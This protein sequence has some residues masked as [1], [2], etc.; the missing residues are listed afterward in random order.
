[1]LCFAGLWLFGWCS[2]LGVLV[3]LFADGL[4]VVCFD[5]LFLVFCFLCLLC[6]LV[7]VAC[8]CLLLV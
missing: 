4:V 2:C 7:V 8:C 1:M 3:D 5:C 6:E